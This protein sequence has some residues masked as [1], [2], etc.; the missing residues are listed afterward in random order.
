MP[1]G[2]WILS[3]RRV[4][5]FQQMDQ[6]MKLPWQLIQ[7]RFGHGRGADV[8]AAGRQQQG[9]RANHVDGRHQGQI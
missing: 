2:S 3:A 9:G 6:F 8:A 5:Y 4:F 1:E 7:G